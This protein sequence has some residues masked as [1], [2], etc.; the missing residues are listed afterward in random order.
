MFGAEDARIAVVDQGIEVAVGDSDHAAAVSAVAAAGAA[1]RDVFFAPERGR[2][3]SA[4]AGDDFDTG[5]VK[6]FHGG[7]PG[8]GEKK[9]PHLDGQG[10]G[11]W[12]P[13]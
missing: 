7:I 6:E 5:F 4:L 1:A 3:V 13:E 12:H 2:A 8:S 10:F 11:G 9:K